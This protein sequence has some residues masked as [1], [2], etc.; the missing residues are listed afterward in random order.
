M[1]NHLDDALLHAMDG[2][3]LSRVR[4]EFNRLRILPI[5]SPHP[6]QPNRK[7]SGHGHLG[8]S[9]FPTHHQVHIPTSPVG[10]TSCGCLRCFSQQEA[11]QRV[12]LLGDMPEPLPASTGVF[13]GNEPGVAADL[14]ATRKPIGCPDDESVDQPGDG[15]TRMESFEVTLHFSGNALIRT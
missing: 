8:N 1:P 11:Q 7:F 14:L 10:V 2:S 6:V 4:T 13:T 12:A 3:E 5:V 9:F 15:S